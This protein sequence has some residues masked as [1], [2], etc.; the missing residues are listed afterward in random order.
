MLALCRV[1]KDFK[2]MAIEAF[3]ESNM[4]HD[5]GYCDPIRRKTIFYDRGEDVDDTSYPPLL[6]DVSD[7]DDSNPE[8]EVPRLPAS[9]GNRELPEDHSLSKE[10]FFSDNSTVTPSDEFWIMHLTARSLGKIRTKPPTRDHIL[11]RKIAEYIWKH[12]RDQHL[13]KGSP[14]EIQLEDLVRAVCEVAV[15]NA[16]MMGRRDFFI[17]I[18]P[19]DFD[20]TAFDVD[21][22]SLV[23]KGALMAMAVYLNDTTLLGDILS[24]SQERAQP[25]VGTRPPPR[26]LDI[27]VPEAELRECEKDGRKPPECGKS[28][29]R[30]ANPMRIAVQMDNIQCGSIMLNTPSLQDTLAI[31]GRTDFHSRSRAGIRLSQLLDRTTDLEIFNLAYDAIMAGYNEEE[32]VWW[33][34]G[35]G[36]HYADSLTSWGVRRFQRAVLDDCLPIARRLLDLGY[37]LDPEHYMSDSGD[38]RLQSYTFFVESLWSMDIALPIAAKRG[39]LDMVKLLIEAG[40]Q[41]KRKNFRKAM[42]IALEQGNN[43]MLKVLLTAESYRETKYVAMAGNDVKTFPGSLL[44]MTSA[45]EVKDPEAFLKDPRFSQTFQL[46]ADPSDEHASIQVKYSDYGYHNAADEKVLLFFAPLCASRIFHCAKDELAKKY[47]VRIVVMDRPGF[48]GT[49]PVKLEKRPAMCRKIL[50]PERPYLAIGA[51]WILP[52]HSHVMTMSVTQSLPA[53][54]L[55]QADKLIGFVNGTLGPVVATSAGISQ[56]FGGGKKKNVQGGAEETMADALFEESLEPFLFKLVHAESIRGFSDESLFL[57]QKIEGVSGWGDWTDYD[58]L[59]PKLV[60]ALKGVGK[61]LTVD[62]YYAEEDS[63]IGAPG[64]DGPEWLN[65][66]FK[67]DEVGQVITY[68]TE[69]IPAA[70]HDTIWSIRRGVPLDVFK[71]LAG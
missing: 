44:S 39:K 54:M 28:L 23:F 34:K 1:S 48:G 29:V 25:Q 56:M 38:Y 13:S 5:V 57:M 60:Q 24:T 52:S 42:L 62:V 33:T 45:T 31:F 6:E 37:S 51:P 32:R 20:A 30:L 22:S 63:M 36:F 4:L 27:W 49:D 66:C 71:K 2:D 17:G 58:D 8:S 65:S 10:E 21:E 11:L 9:A 70:D 43:E 53:S 59:V 12:R 41:K 7:N 50:N 67:G 14:P 35:F 61:K 69:T 46:P 68:N 16:A 26:S 47:R 64:T 18:Q 3:L 19:P 15:K 55:A 40:A